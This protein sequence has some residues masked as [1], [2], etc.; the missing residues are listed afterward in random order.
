MKTKNV[1]FIL[2][3]VILIVLLVFIF[4]MNKSDQIK[5]NDDMIKK[6]NDNSNLPINLL[7]KYDETNSFLSNLNFL[8]NYMSY[9]YD[10]D[11]ISLSFYGYPNDES[12]YYLG[13]III[14]SNNYNILGINTDTSYADATEILKKYNLDKEYKNIKVE[15]I[16]IDEKIEEISIKVESKY[17][18]NRVY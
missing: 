14:K 10:N 18:G 3:G 16:N 13:E 11:D 7:E 4:F 15:I 9:D 17:L 2:I 1:L 12:D 6:I 5:I 8:K